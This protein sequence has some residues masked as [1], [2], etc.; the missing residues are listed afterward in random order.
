MPAFNVCATVA[1]MTS[2]METPLHALEIVTTRLG[3]SKLKKEQKDAILSFLAGRDV[4]IVLPT[5]YRKILCYACLP[6][7]YDLLMKKTGSVAIIISPL[8]A[9]MDDQIHKFTTTELITCARV[10]QSADT[11]IV[12][13]GINILLPVYGI[14]NSKWYSVFH[15]ILV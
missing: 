5:G 10:G 11:D 2:E 15:G 7:V 13:G 3:Y 1:T 6:M 4:F 14:T 9:L 12:L 8:I